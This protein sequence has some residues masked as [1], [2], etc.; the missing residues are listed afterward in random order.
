MSDEN[1]DVN[2]EIEENVK[3]DTTTKENIEKEEQE[4]RNN[5]NK[6]SENGENAQQWSDCV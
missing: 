4:E 2:K 6:N 5:G 1:I 3:E